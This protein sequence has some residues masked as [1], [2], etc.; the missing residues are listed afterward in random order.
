MVG[1]APNI[2]YFKVVFWSWTAKDKKERITNESSQ[3]EQ[4]LWSKKAAWSFVVVGQI[5]LKIRVITYKFLHFLVWNVFRMCTLD[6]CQSISGNFCRLPGILWA[7][8]A[9]RV[10]TC[11]KLHFVELE[12]S[13]CQFLLFF[14]MSCI[15]QQSSYHQAFWILYLSIYVVDWYKFVDKRISKTRKTVIVMSQRTPSWKCLCTES[16]TWSL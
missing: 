3:Y 5:S 10:S 11:C 8:S 16:G 12:A 6:H 7:H 1:R 14:Y 15:Q 2:G 9:S 13:R 4:S